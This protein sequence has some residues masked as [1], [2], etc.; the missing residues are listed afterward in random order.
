MVKPKCL[1]KDSENTNELF[2]NTFCHVTMLTYTQV[3]FVVD[4]II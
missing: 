2:P 4:S 3:L 1:A